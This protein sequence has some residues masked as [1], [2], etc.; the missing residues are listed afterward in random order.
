VSP[1]PP[2]PHP[3]DPDAPG[4]PHPA[5]PDAPGAGPLP[6]QPGRG[7][8]APGETVLLVDA[9]GRRR[10]VRLASGG[11]SHSHQGV[12][13]H[14]E[15][16]G[17][18]EGSSVR[19]NTGARFLAL[20]P[21]LAERVLEMPRGAQV[22]YPKDLGA[23]LM[24]GD[25]FP[26]AR[27]LEAGVGSGALSLALLRAGAVVVGYERR[28]E[29]ARRAEANVTDALGPVGD[30]YLVRAKDVYDGIDERELDRILLDLPEP[31]RVVGAAEEALRPGGLLVCYLPTINQTAELRASLAGSRFGLA[32]TLEVLERRWHVEGRS[33]RPVHRMVAH[34]GFLTVARLLAEPEGKGR[35]S[36]A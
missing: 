35:A 4:A 2:P 3:A 5:D 18:P 11:V 8:L 36:E 1:E 14:D 21:T 25:V 24:L 26:G 28:P 31:W 34:T 23:I 15:L 6:A 19:T 33:V 32:E 22:I 9:K 12:V 16:I 27:V 20:R 17:R 10:L 29:F 7:P 30:R 13:R